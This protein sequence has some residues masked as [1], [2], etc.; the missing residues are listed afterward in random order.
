M[1]K[2]YKMQSQ[3]PQIKPWLDFLYYK[4]GNGQFDFYLQYSEQEGIKTKWKKYSEVCFDFENPKS[5][6]FLSKVNQRQILPCEVV[7]DLESQEELQ[8]VLNALNPLGLNLYVYSTGSRG[9]HIHIFFKQILSSEQKTAIIK[10]FGAD[11]MKAGDKCLIA[12]EFAPH[13]KSGKI[14]Q[15]VEVK[16]EM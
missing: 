13:W 3:I 16:N 10:H 9:F 15:L 7:L 1:F 2:S 11:T 6:W 14:K 12:L 8:P 5:Q 4:V